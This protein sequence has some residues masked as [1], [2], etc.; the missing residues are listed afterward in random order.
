MFKRTSNIFWRAGT[1]NAWDGT[2][3]EGLARARALE[4][5]EAAAGGLDSGEEAGLL[6]RRG[7]ISILVLYLKVNQ[8]FNDTPNKLGSR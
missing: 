8:G 3:N 2:V 6:S 7:H 1:V 4:V 5:G